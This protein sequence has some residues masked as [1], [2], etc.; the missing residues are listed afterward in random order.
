MVACEQGWGSAE[1]E[2]V[3]IKAHED[4]FVKD[5]HYLYWGDSFTQMLIM[6]M[7]LIKCEVYVNLKLDKTIE[8]CYTIIMVNQVYLQY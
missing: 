6:F 2:G 5:I 1:W 3:I 4:T 8:M 7:I